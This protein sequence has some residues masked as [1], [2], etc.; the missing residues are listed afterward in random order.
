MKWQSVPQ[1]SVKE[2]TDLESNPAFTAQPCIISSCDSFT[3]L[4]V[5][6]VEIILRGVAIKMF[7]SLLFL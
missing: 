7:C 1:G 5:L 4:L 6:G 3:V 2:S